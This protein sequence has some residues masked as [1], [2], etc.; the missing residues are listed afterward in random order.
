MTKPVK[1]IKHLPISIDFPLFLKLN[2]GN[3]FHRPRS[4]I[5]CYTGIVKE[6]LLKRASIEICAFESRLHSQSVRTQT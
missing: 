5:F 2:A 4:F 6:P 3:G 1:L